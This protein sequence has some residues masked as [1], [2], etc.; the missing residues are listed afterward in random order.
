MG[1]EFRCFKILQMQDW[2]LYCFD[3]ICFWG[4][5]CQFYHFLPVRS[6]FALAVPD[7]RAHTPKIEVFSSQHL[8]LPTERVCSN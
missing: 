3:P 1:K 2:C 5:Q 7:S 4:I 8:V 6:A